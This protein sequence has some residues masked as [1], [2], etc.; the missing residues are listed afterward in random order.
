MRLAFFILFTLVLLSCRKECNSTIHQGA[1]DAATATWVPDSLNDS[2]HFNLEGN[3]STQ[4]VSTISVREG[5]QYPEGGTDCKDLFMTSYKLT[6]FETGTDKFTHSVEQN[7]VNGSR[8]RLSFNNTVFAFYTGKL[9]GSYEYS[10]NDTESVWGSYQRYDSV[11]INN[12][13][14][15]PVYWINALVPAEPV[16]INV[17]F[18][19]TP[20]W[21]VVKY[22]NDTLTWVLNR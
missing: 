19:V 5:W 14:Y 7:E 3:T 8:V 4:P 12:Q 10:V 6:N 1:I 2:L 17:Q 18:F 22:V 16:R 13:T 9:N 21:G 11:I 15:K 20:H